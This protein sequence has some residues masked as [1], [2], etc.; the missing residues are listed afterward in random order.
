MAMAVSTD[1]HHSYIARSEDEDQVDEDDGDDA[2]PT[3]RMPAHLRSQS[4]VFGHHLPLARPHTST[5]A[6][7]QS[8]SSAAIMDPPQTPQSSSSFSTS[9]LSRASP[10]PARSV[11]VPGY[12]PGMPRPMTPRN[13]D[14][15]DL[16]SS[17]TTPR[18][19]SPPA[20]TSSTAAARRESLSSKTPLFLSRSPGRYTPVPVQDIFSSSVS[21]SG[22]MSISNDFDDSG[23]SS[24]SSSPTQSRR[25]PASPLSGPA[26]QPLGITRSPSRNSSSRPSTP[27]NIVWVA[28]GAENGT[29][30]ESTTSPPRST[31][32]RHSRNNSWIGNGVGEGS[33]TLAEL[34]MAYGQQQLHHR[35]PSRTGGAGS[36]PSVDLSSPFSS[37]SSSAHV[38][39]LIST[40]SSTSSTSSISA[41]SS[42]H[43]TASTSS[44]SMSASSSQTHVTATASNPLSLPL[45]HSSFSSVPNLGVMNTGLAGGQG[46]ALVGQMG[47]DVGSGVGALSQAASTQGASIY[48]PSSTTTADGGT[49]PLSPQFTFPQ[50]QRSG[51]PTQTQNGAQGYGHYGGYSG[52]G[53]YHAPGGYGSLSQRN[54]VSPAFPG[55]ISSGGGMMNGTRRSSRQAPVGSIG[56]GGPGLGFGPGAFGLGSLPI[57]NSSRS[58]LDSAGSSFHSWDEPDRV[59]GVFSETDVAVAWHEFGEG[60]RGY[61]DPIV[62]GN[63]NGHAVIDDAE[64]TLLQYAGLRQSDIQAIQEKLV[65]AALVKAANTDPRDRAPSALRRRRPSTSQSNYSRVRLFY[66]HTTRLVRLTQHNRSRLRVRRRKANRH[67]LARPM[68]TIA[69]PRHYLTLLFRASAPILLPPPLELSMGHRRRRLQ[70]IHTYPPLRWIMEN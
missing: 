48:T 61:E 42:S 45:S 27:S 29:G 57:A 51:T 26:F 41:A 35:S 4:F 20:Q 13:F 31:G 11:P 30:R 53:G 68:I 64:D 56:G 65:M 32:G 37:G 8:A 52:S 19:T 69:K 28:P 58:S 47:P 38:S 39:S 10:I 12:V 7:S 50:Q 60:S 9:A 59:L 24:V 67:R 43:S 2:S 22:A 23:L 6:Y 49:S 14:I 63:A 62:N 40:T 54:P 5:H 1:H 36:R 55:P 15:E 46:Q 34:Q 16:R 25:R 44:S 18:A 3:S 33:V 66:Y 70:L 17:S 21:S